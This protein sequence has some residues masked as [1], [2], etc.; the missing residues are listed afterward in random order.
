MSIL[1][2]AVVSSGLTWLGNYVLN[3]PAQAAEAIEQVKNEQSIDRQRI[4]TLEA[5]NK[6]LTNWLT[7]IEGKLDKVISGK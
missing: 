3:S 1:T 4:A 2:V 5:D 7:R 6:S